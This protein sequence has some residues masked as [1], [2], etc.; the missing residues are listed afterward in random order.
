MT[1]DK[2]FEERREVEAVRGASMCEFVGK[3]L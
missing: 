2:A 3:F 1:L